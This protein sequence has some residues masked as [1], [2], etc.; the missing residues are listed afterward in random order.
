V[1]LL[2]AFVKWVFYIVGGWLA[3]HIVLAVLVAVFAQS[4][5]SGAKISLG[6]M[7]KE[8]IMTGALLSYSDNVGPDLAEGKRIGDKALQSKSSDN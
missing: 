5:P 7:Q 4:I 1:K 6:L 8:V 3:I 2:V